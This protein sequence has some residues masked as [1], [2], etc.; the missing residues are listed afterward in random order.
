M[1]RDV[2]T[3][4]RPGA[5]AAGEAEQAEGIGKG[6]LSGRLGGDHAADQAKPAGAAPA[7]PAPAAAAAK[8][9]TITS[10]TQA[11]APA[12]ANTRTTVGVGELV[13]FTGS[14]EGDWSVSGGKTMTDVAKVPTVQWQAPGSPGSYT[15]TLT[16]DTR[17]ATKTIVV[18]APNAIYFKKTADKT[19][20]SGQGVGMT[21]NMDIGPKTVSFGAVQIKE[22]AGPATG[23]WG[24]FAKKQNLGH[25]PRASWTYINADNTAERPDEAYFDGWPAPFEP[26]GLTWSIPNLWSL[27]EEGGEGKTFATVTQTMHIADTKGTSVIT[28]GGQSASRQATK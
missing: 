7:A 26:G 24:Y 1:D 19:F 13:D 18:V 21:L 27:V 6:T 11:K 8:A 12:A 14:E 25:Q 17:K 23:V 10:A 15:I 5:Q 2:E 3:Q 28:K 20:G 4:T 22:K 16:V 9:L